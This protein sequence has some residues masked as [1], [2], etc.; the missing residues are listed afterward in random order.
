MKGIYKYVDLKTGDVVYVGKDSNIDK[1]MRH[2]DHLSP[3]YYD[4]QQIN[5]VLQNNPERYEYQVIY[6]GDFDDD[7][8]NVLEINTIADEQ[9]IFNFTKGGDGTSGYKHTEEA[10]KKMSEAHKGK[11]FSEEARKKMSEAHK[12]LQVGRNNPMY[13]KTGESNPMYG[14][15][16]SE[17]ARRKMSEAKSGE[18][19]PFYGTRNPEHS[20]RMSGE[21]NPRAKYTLWDISFVHYN[22]KDMFKNNRKMNPRKCF[23]LKYNGKQVPIGGFHDFVSVEIINELIQEAIQK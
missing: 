14:R 16:H 19:H 18:N 21:N 12:G 7:L 1:N 8:L 6:A 15:K 3:A 13:G 11:T 17:E 2:R 4:V 20:K 5:R 22:K 23:H 10:R 9:P